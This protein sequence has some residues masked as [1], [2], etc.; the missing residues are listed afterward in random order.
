MDTLVLTPIESVWLA[1]EGTPRD[2]QEALL[3]A[4][5][6]DITAVLIEYRYPVSALSLPMLLEKTSLDDMT[7]TPVA[8]QVQRLWVLF[9]PFFQL[10]MGL[11]LLIGLSAG[12]TILLSNR[13]TQ[14]QRL[15]DLAVLRVMGVP[16]RRLGVLILCEFIAV[17]LFA[18][19]VFS[20]ALGLLFGWLNHAYGWLIQ[21]L[22]MMEWRT[23]ALVMGSALLLMLSGAGLCAYRLLQQSVSQVLQSR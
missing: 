14:P 8:P 23:V 2:A 17:W 11:S 3:L 1:H 16:P 21:P 15:R 10:L 5:S 4:Q 9:E 6:R 19:G 13:L 20:V 22:L 7:V 18:C 12:I